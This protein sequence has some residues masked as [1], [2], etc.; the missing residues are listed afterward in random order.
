MYGGGEETIMV[1]KWWVRLAKPSTNEGLQICGGDRTRL[2]RE[3]CRLAQE[4]E[5]CEKV[6]V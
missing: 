4:I 2:E 5:Y 1:K 3:L 6:K